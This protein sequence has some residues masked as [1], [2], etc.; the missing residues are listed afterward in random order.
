MMAQD[1]I[2]GLQQARKKRQQAQA[3]ELRASAAR[4]E[5]EAQRLRDVVEAARQ[6]RARVVAAT[7]KVTARWPPLTGEFDRGLGVKLRARPI[8]KRITFNRPLATGYATVRDQGFNVTGGRVTGARR[9]DRRSDRWEL[10]IVSDRSGDMVVVSTDALRGKG[11][12]TL[13]TQISTTI[14]VK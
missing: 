7:P 9:V 13:G 3:D 12:R 14:V 2:Y 5:K 10:T 1:A 6:E 4:R 11:G 8:R